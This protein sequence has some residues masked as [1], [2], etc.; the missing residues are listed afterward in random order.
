M[1]SAN[2][3]DKMIQTHKNI[4]AVLSEVRVKLDTNTP[5]I[6]FLGELSHQVAK[7]IDLIKE[8][9]NMNEFFHDQIK[10]SCE[11]LFNDRVEE[12]IDGLEERLSDHEDDIEDC[13][14]RIES[15]ED[16]ISGLQD[17]GKGLDADGV[18]VIIA[19]AFVDASKAVTA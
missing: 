3:H 19:N 4:I 2:T 9:I 10:I 5:S 18:R 6:P 11:E 12:R 7:A 8:P 15:C 14:S 13:K 16:D 17:E 1:L